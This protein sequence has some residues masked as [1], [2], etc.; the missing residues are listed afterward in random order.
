MEDG[1]YLTSALPGVLLAL[2]L[3]IAALEFTRPLGTHVYGWVLGSGLLLML[4]YATRF[5]A[6]CMPRFELDSAGWIPV[7]WKVPR[8]WVP[9]G[10]SD[11]ERCY[12]PE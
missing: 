3:M 6:R 5:V 12:F 2:G 11:F 8:C 4:G 9:D 7:K 1:V 10:G